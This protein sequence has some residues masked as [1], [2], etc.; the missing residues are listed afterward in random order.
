MNIFYQQ[1][2]QVYLYCVFARLE[3]SPLV[4]YPPSPKT[5]KARHKAIN[6]T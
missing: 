3:I 2:E 1:K 5:N 4:G 6:L